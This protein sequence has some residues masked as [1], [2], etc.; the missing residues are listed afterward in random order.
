MCYT[1]NINQFITYSISYN[2]QIHILDKKYQTFVE[3]NRIKKQKQLEEI[4]H[5]E[6]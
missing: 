1:I 3:A 5:D 2:G 6:G 4:F